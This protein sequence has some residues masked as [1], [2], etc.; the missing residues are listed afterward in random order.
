MRMRR[1]NQ[2]AWDTMFPQTITTNILRDDDNDNT[3]VLETH[4]IGYDHHI[5]NNNRHFNHATSHGTSH[6]RFEV[7]FPDM[8]SLPD[9]F[10]LLLTIHTKM[11]AEPQ[12]IFNGGDPKY[13]KSASGERIPGGQVAGTVLLLAWSEPSDAW[14]LLSVSDTNDITKIVIPSVAEHYVE[15]TE[16]Q[17]VFVIPDFDKNTCS[18]E[19]NYGQTVLRLNKDYT[20]TIGVKNSITLTTFSL[21]AGDILH[22]KITS[23]EVVSR[24]SNVTYNIETVDYT[25]TATMDDQHVF[26]LPAGAQDP[27]IAQMDLNYMQTI[28]RNGLDYIKESDRITT[29]DFGLESGEELVAHCIKLTETDGAVMPRGWNVPGAY[30]YEIKTIHT[31]FTAQE[32]GVQVIPVPGYVRTRDELVVVKDN[33]VLVYDVDYEVD[34][35]NQVVLHDEH[36]LTTGA[37]V[38]FTIF[39]GAVQDTPPFVVE[40]DK[41]GDGQHILL[42]FSYDLLRD[43][44]TVV[45][46]LTHELLAAP[47]IKC[48]EGPAEAI[49]DNFGAPI[50]GGYIAG[51]YL[52]C[53]YNYDQKRW[54][55]M[56]HGHYDISDSYPVYQFNEGDA[57]F[58]AGHAYADQEP[59]HIGELAI[60][61]GL[62]ATPVDIDIHPTE[63]PGF[64]D[65]GVTPKTIGDI[66]YSADNTFLYVGNT[67]NATSAFHWTA[68]TAESN[69]NFKS[70]IT[71]AIDN[72]VD[73][74]VTNPGRIKTRTVVYT[75]SQTGVYNIP[76]EGFTPSKE[77]IFLVN[78]GQT[79]LREGIDYYITNTGV[80]L[81]A[82]R[83]NTGESI[84][85]TVV[86]DSGD[87]AVENV[88][89]INGAT[90]LTAG[91]L[92]HTD[93]GPALIPEEHTH[94]IIQTPGYYQGKFYLWNGI[95]YQ[96]V[97]D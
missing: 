75:A 34:S 42:D 26:M 24:S 66:W 15:A 30:T 63:H 86:I 10:P 46:K 72:L 2:G 49:L 93:G 8:T 41:G 25:M 5:A 17:T 70:T 37:S 91:W 84:M 32:D 74:I 51:S 6:R 52:W 12:I 58:I 22:F 61:H 54:Y 36:A 94:Y 40:T 18:L 88:F 79:L 56:S 1:F 33:K 78:Y 11:D 80:E 19:V 3:S 67:G 62:S 85:V 92:S 4:L 28:L 73:L 81:S 59:D 95:E 57:H 31:S 97:R 43:G 82:I 87:I 89:I 21:S 50:T 76:V 47:T 60:P 68:G 71:E 45:I 83:I 9:G 55:S 44:F 14:I 64:E 77:R 96:N 53:V 35:L 38:Y 23:Y 29:I 20:Y 48:L 90:P 16:G 13:I 65:D 27:S 7:D 39:Q 69:V